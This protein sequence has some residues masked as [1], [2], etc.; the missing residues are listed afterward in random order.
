MPLAELPARL[1]AGTRLLG[2]DL[3]EKTI[4]LAI[5]DRDH[6]VG[7]NIFSKL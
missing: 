3:G 7:E 2:L 5:S 4:G 1:P 6:K